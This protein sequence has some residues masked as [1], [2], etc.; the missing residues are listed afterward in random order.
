MSDYTILRR[1]DAPDFTGDLPGAFLGYGRALGLEQVALNV[2]VLA[3][4]TAHVPPGSDAGWGHSHKTQEEIYFVVYGE[5][6]IKLDDDVE[7]LGPLDAVRIAPETIRAV[8]NDGSEEAAFIMC[9]IRIE[10]AMADAQPQ[11]EFWGAD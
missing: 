7:T 4:G 5:V 6:T 8:R 3:P 11:A 10:D 2:R 9:S 1:A